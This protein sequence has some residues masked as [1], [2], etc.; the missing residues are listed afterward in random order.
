MRVR[1]RYENCTDQG[2]AD[3]H[4]LVQK[5]DNYSDIEKI[6]KSNIPQQDDDNV[7]NK[8]ESILDLD[9]Y[10]ASDN[11]DDEKNNSNAR[12]DSNND[13]IPKKN[14]DNKNHDSKNANSDQNDNKDVKNENSVDNMEI[15]ELEDIKK[16]DVNFHNMPK[17]ICEI[18][19]IH[20]KMMNKREHGILFCGHGAYKAHRKLNTF[21]QKT[22]NNMGYG[23]QFSQFNEKRQ[24]VQSKVAHKVFVADSTDVSYT[25]LQA[26]TNA[27][28]LVEDVNMINV[29]DDIN[30]HQTQ[31]QSSNS[32]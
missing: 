8:S 7:I 16:D 10:S 22:A 13:K 17:H 3:V 12:K 29:V 1:N 4:L 18:Q 25:S 32:N 15:Q 24:E 20:I 21:A 28:K 19:F 31:N 23:K 6:N 14:I 30:K 26:D 27:A 5:Y 9:N 2:W 11:K